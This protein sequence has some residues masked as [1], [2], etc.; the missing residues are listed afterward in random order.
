MLSFPSSMATALVML[1]TPHFEAPLEDWAADI[2]W[3]GPRGWGKDH[4]QTT[5]IGA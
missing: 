1:R 2:R 3:V 5:G 4:G